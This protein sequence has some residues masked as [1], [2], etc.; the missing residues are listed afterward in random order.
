MV[1]TTGERKQK[2]NIDSRLLITGASGFLGKSLV[3]KALDEGKSIRLLLLPDEILPSWLV[4]SAAEVDDDR[5]EVYRGDICEPPSI[6]N[7]CVGVG[8]ILHLAGVILA[9]EPNDYER[10]N[11]QGTRNLI[12]LAEKNG[13]REFLYVSSIS[14]KFPNPSYYAQSK[15][16]AEKEVQSS[17]LDWRIVRP[18]L[19]CDQYGGREFLLFRNWVERFSKMVWLPDGGRALK[20]PVH[21]LDLSVALL[22]VLQKEESRE[23]ILEVGGGENISLAQM[24]RLLRAKQGKKTRIVNLPR[25]FLYVPVKI[26]S[27]FVRQ[28]ASPYQALLGLV[29]DAIPNEDAL[30]QKLKSNRR[31]FS[32]FIKDF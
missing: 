28:P 16:A 17:S 23:K 25:W 11:V 20:S 18:T 15:L 29:E 26:L 21:T 9:S 1:M 30:T 13:V 10:V 24:A 2:R 27:L 22:E 3:Q 8:C 4:D 6:A 7:L 5:V 14:V 12:R 31:K 32:T 19:L